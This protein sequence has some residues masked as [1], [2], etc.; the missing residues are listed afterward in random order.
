LTIEKIAKQINLDLSDVPESRHATV[1]REVGDYVTEEILRALSS[2]KSPVAGE[3]FKKLN[4][5]YADEMKDGNR[6]PNLELDGDLLDALRYKSNDRGIE[7]GIFKSSEVPKADG[8]NNF[9]G[10]SKLPTRRFIP[11]DD[12]KFKQQIDTGIKSIVNEYKRKAPSSD[13]FASILAVEESDQRVDI[14]VGD[15]FNDD[16]MEAF[17]RDNGYI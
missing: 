1:K 6:T 10:D 8:H 9:S 7:I 15:L 5:E 12:Q 17:L 14:Q 11:K 2:G 3:S 4:K 16:F 13:P